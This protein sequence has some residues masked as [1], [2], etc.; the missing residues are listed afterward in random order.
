ML[1]LTG[2]QC[3]F[4]CSAVTVTRVNITHVFPFLVQPLPFR[5]LLQLLYI[6]NRGTTKL[7]VTLEVTE[8]TG[9]ISSFLLYLHRWQR[10][11]ILSQQN[12][13]NAP[14]DTVIQKK[15]C[16]AG[17]ASCF[18]LSCEAVQRKVFQYTGIS[19]F[20]MP[21]SH[22]LCVHEPFPSQHNPCSRSWADLR[23][24]RL[25][26][27]GLCTFVF[28]ADLQLLTSDCRHKYQNYPEILFRMFWIPSRG[29]FPEN[30]DTNSCCP[31]S[32]MVQGPCPSGAVVS[33]VLDGALGQIKTFDMVYEHV[34]SVHV[35]KDCTSSFSHAGPQ[36][37]TS[38]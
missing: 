4:C 20:L 35:S 15:K 2:T 9:L 34:F 32:R 25:A 16:V 5:F 28:V 18:P 22:W 12:Q 6:K 38:L 31:E 8:I 19:I 29:N 26:S 3:C 24:R 37:P 36:M 23:T 1:L 7:L 17:A 11:A 13:W 30:L 27:V 33:F 10:Q 14:N 21:K